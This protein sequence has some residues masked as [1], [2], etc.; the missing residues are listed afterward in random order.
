MEDNGD[1]H[2]SL[3]DPLPNTCWTVRRWRFS[4]QHEVLGGSLGQP[5]G[6]QDDQQQIFKQANEAHRHQTPP[7]PP[8]RGRR[9]G[10]RHLRQDRGS[11]RGSAHD[12]FRHEDVL[13][14]RGRSDECWVSVLGGMVCLR[15]EFRSRRG[16]ILENKARH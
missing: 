6:H 1:K 11:T 10:S 3:L 15:F 14:A 2:A 9:K 16:K 12:T 5:R 7:H 4:S 8:C 13:K